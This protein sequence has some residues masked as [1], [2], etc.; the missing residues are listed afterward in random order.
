MNA[1]RIALSLPRLLG[2]VYAACF[3]V[4]FSVCLSVSLSA[5]N[6]WVED[7]ADL[8]ARSAVQAAGPDCASCHGYPLKDLN[9]EY[10]LV[11]AVG[12]R[13]LNGAITC[14]DCHSQS[15]RA[16]AVVLI[17]SLYETPEGEKYG[18][19]D[20]PNANDTTKGKPSFVIRSL[21]LVDIDTL[22]QNHP[23][24]LGVRPGP[25]PLFQEYVTALAHMNRVVDVSFDSRNSDTIRFLGQKAAYNPAQETCSAVACHPG[26]KPYSF[27]SVAK[28]L[29]ELKDL[30]E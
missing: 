17:D 8:T 20:F 14:L 15:V 16:A 9:H 10:H 18:T 5:C 11:E 29:P 28:G 12:N 27:G 1:R 3:S 25:K 13:D 7:P 6:G 2:L 30:E 19:V 26:N 24:S 4:W 21:P 22:H 23:V